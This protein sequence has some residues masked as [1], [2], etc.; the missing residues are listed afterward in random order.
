MFLSSGRDGKL[1]VWD[2]DR[3][4]VVE[5]FS[6][7]EPINKHCIGEPEV[8]ALV[9][10]AARTN[11]LQLVDLRTGSTCHTLGSRTLG[12]HA[13]QGHSGEVNCCAWSRADPWVLASGSADKKIMLWD[14]RQSRSYL[15]YL[16]Y[17][18]VRYKKKKDIK[19]ANMSHQSGVHGLVYSSCGRF[20]YSL[21]NDKRIRKWDTVTSKNLK[22]KFPEVETKCRGSIDLVSVEDG[23]KDLLFVPENSKIAVF[24]A[25][26]G[27]KLSSLDGHLYNVNCLDL[28]RAKVQLYS[29][30]RDRFILQWDTPLQIAAARASKEEHREER[31]DI[32]PYTVD[33]WTSDEDED[34]DG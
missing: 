9:A 33:T 25:G 17:N 26:S 7:G 18:N 10:V 28:G 2:S 30:G 12:G 4:I 23:V 1:Q 13:L 11:H 16:D 27:C 15:T 32:N 14:V 31:K 22:T 19:L 3:G 8:G 24:D 5:E 20:L 6:V 29:G 21:G 34:E